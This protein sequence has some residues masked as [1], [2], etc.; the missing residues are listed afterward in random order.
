MLTASF[1][2]V[3]EEIFLKPIFLFCVKLNE[4][5]EKT[6]F[7]PKED[8]YGN[9]SAHLPGQVRSESCPEVILIPTLK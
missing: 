4:A 1:F 5:S 7:P 6:S 9:A 2:S 3:S 8:I